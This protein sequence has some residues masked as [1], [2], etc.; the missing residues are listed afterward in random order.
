MYGYIYVTTNII[1]G[2]VYVGKKTSPFNPNY[3]GS[4]R[5]ITN[6]VNKYGPDNFKVSVIEYADNL[7]DLNQKEIYWIQHYKDEGFEM[8]NISRGGDGGDT[9]LNLSE[10]DRRV[11]L[12][13][14]KKNGYFSHITKTQFKELLEHSVETRRK[15]AEERGYWFSEEARKHMSEGQK[16]RKPFTAEKQ[17]EISRRRTETRKRNGYRHSKETLE[18]ISRSNKGRV[19]SEE[20]RRKLSENRKG[21]HCGSDNPFYGKH[22]SDEVKQLLSE[23]NKLGICGSKGRKWMNNGSSNIRVK[24]ED[25][26]TYIDSGYVFGRL[27]FHYKERS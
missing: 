23:Y 18:K 11:R 14:L 22:H 9:Y 12:D 1:S 13:N 17:A 7:S 27:P 4:G 20:Y 5:Y 2:K 25:A 19:F 8:Y 26:P 6:A 24:P 3:L 21:T 16:N 10:K 15:N